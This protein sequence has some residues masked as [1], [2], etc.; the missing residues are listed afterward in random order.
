MNDFLGYRIEE[1]IGRGGMGVVHRAFDLR[2]KRLVAL[3]L[4]APE[5]TR[6]ERFRARFARE[7]ELAMSLEHP[8]VVPIYDAGE[9]D[10]QLYIAMRLVEGSDLETLLRE[11]GALEPVRALAIC[12]QIA[13]A[14]DAA[15]LKGLV[16]RDVKPSNVLLDLSEHV[17]LADFGLSRRLDEL[18][19]DAG[20][21]RSVGTP[22]YIA[23]E[24]L[25]R[26]AVDGRAD[27]YSLGCV[28]FECLTGERVFAAKSRL[29]VAWA[30]LEEEPP[31][32]SQRKAGLSEAIDVVLARA[33]AKDPAQRYATCVAL[34]SAAAGALGVRRP[35]S[36]GR[37]VAAAVIAAVV[38]AL[39]T[40]LSF[41]FTAHRG[42]AV[43]AP[44]VSGNTLARIDPR[45]NSVQRVIE[46]SAGPA[47]V[48]AYGHRV[49][50][51]SRGTATISEID[52]TTN[53]TV[54]TTA[55]RATPLDFSG[56]IGPALAADARGAWIVGSQL[57]GP[58]LLTLVRLDGTRRQYRI[59]G[60]PS[61][62]ALSK[63]AVWII[64]RDRLLRVDP[65]TGE[66]S[67][68]AQFGASS[69]VDSVASGLGYVWVG[70][71]SR[72]KLYRINPESGSAIS[73]DLGRRSNRPVVES[74]R[75]WVGI[76]D[77]GG[78]TALVDRRPLAVYQHL[79]CCHLTNDVGDAG[80]G[81]SWE[82]VQSNGTVVRWSGATHE[83]EKVIQLTD[84][85]YY[86]GSCLTSL[87]TGAGGVWVTAAP[88]VH[89][90]C[91]G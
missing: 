66:T 65:E 4:V 5:L 33:L 29:A 43:A 28:L 27:V 88:A 55:I 38:L 20:A 39:A 34:V 8:N 72:A 67:L 2:L 9:V 16:H 68:R 42:R 32:A 70:S 44:R 26:G 7:S 78:D 81:S 63:N 69:G 84:A 31:R 49:W 18:G 10:G 80:F 17:Y 87:A 1:P 75:I 25:D 83:L 45:T 89:E 60:L 30:H 41:A 58:S 73:L 71:S 85:P 53:R 48:A 57:G 36:R 59:P 51:Y 19:D 23:P 62:V 6:D 14:L 77:R 56:Q 15:H 13:A 64:A 82:T 3:K 22:A 50:V 21:G 74:G 79:G 54:H 24:Q 12:V 61:A 52:A 47:A 90:R 91:A 76:S 46:V 35:G 40:S 37:R 11:D 86:D